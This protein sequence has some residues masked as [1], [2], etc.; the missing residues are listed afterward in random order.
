MQVQNTLRTLRSFYLL[1]I[2]SID[3]SLFLQLHP[4][5]QSWSKDMDPSRSQRYR[6]MA[7]KV[8]ITYCR[9]NAFLLHQYIQPHILDML[10][11]LKSQNIHINDLMAAGKFLQQQGR[12]Q[13]VAEL[14]ETALDTMGNS[15]GDNK[16]Y[17]GNIWLE[18]TG[19][20]VNGRWNG[21]AGHDHSSGRFGDDI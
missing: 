15:T 14:F 6:A 3:D 19:I 7:L 21:K 4:L 11:Q 16:E 2:T 18:F 20:K 5:I 17:R 1:S 8:L 10:H 9:D 13:A 12:Y